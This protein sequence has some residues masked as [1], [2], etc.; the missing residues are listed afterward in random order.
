MVV[1]VKRGWSDRTAVLAAAA[2]I[3]VM[4]VV[5]AISHD[6][7]LVL[8]VFPL[9]VLAGFVAVMTR[10]DPLAWSLVF[11][12]TAWAMLQLSRSSLVVAPAFLS[13]KY[14][15]DRAR[16]GAAALRGVAVRAE[17]RPRFGGRRAGE[18]EAAEA[19]VGEGASDRGTERGGGRPTS[20]D[21]R[22]GERAG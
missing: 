17:T 14:A 9:A 4:S 19:V 11:G 22:R 12:L 8:Y 15:D 13:S 5:P 18:P 20:R 2:C 16:A 1:L 7:K 21:E 10:R 3:P 6:Y